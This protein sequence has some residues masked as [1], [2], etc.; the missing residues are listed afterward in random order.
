MLISIGDLR[1][2]VLLCKVLVSML[3][4]LL[5]LCVNRGLTVPEFPLLLLTVG[6]YIAARRNLGADVDATLLPV[7]YN[8]AGV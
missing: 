8:C 3:H 7:V 1:H 2:A 6:E 5:L 4:M